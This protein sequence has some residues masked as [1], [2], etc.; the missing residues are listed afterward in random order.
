[1]C[2]GCAARSGS[3]ARGGSSMSITWFNGRSQNGVL[4]SHP[5]PTF[6]PFI[7]TLLP[8]LVTL[9]NDRYYKIIAEALRVT[10]EVGLIN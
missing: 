1:M 9:V 8:H 5:P 2:T 3:P 7:P 10:S 4:A 6:Q